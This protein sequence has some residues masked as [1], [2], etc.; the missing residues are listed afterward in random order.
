MEA[1]EVSVTFAVNYVTRSTGRLAASV[2]YIVRLPITGNASAGVF[3]RNE[4]SS[5]PAHQC[6]LRALIRLD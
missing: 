5:Q 1:I 3:T 6:R 2:T 4:I